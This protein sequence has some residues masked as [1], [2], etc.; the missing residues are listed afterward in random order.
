[1]NAAA[2]YHEARTPLCCALDPET[3][4]ITLRTGQEVD[5]VTLIYADPYEAGIAGGEESWQGR[6]MEMRPAAQ[7]EHC[8]LWRA[9]LR[10]PYRRLRY[11]FEVGQGGEA[12]YYYEDGLRSK[13]QLDNRVQCFTMPWM[14]PSDVIAPPDWVRQTVWYQIFPDRFCRGGSGRPGGLPW[15]DGPVTNADRFGGDLAGITAKLPYLA[16]LG[17]NG[18]YL[19]PLFASGSIHKYDTTDYA[20]VDPDFGTEADLEQLVRTAHSLGIRVMLDAVFNH[21]GPGFAPWRDVVGHGPSSPY[22]NWFFIRQWPF[23][24]G[25]T[26]DGRYF[27]FAFHGGMP[28]LNTNNPDVQEYLT[29][30]CES[31]V[32]RYD[33][34]A[35]RFDVGNEIAHSF[36]RRLRARLKARKPSL[37]LLGEIWHDAPA[38]LEG[39]E[40]DAVM[41]Y[42]LQSAIR[43]FF[44]DKAQP[45]AAFGWDVGRCMSVYAPQVNTV[46]FTLLDS[47]DTI[48]LRNRVSGEAEFWQQL[49]ALFTLPGSPCVYY[50]T[51]LMLEGGPDPD[52]RR[53]MPWARLEAEGPH[54]VLCQL[55]ALRRQEPA[56]QSSEIQ[57]L[58]GEGRLVRYRRGEP[59]PGQL[60]VCLNAGRR[61]EA[62]G[63]GGAD[64]FALA[65]DGETLAPGGI[66]IRRV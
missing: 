18:L 59:G 49:A 10:P 32:Q 3:L 57:F 39:D 29:A 2:I 38:W 51:E 24:E 9:V 19:N 47:H 25:E 61:P 4:Q 63:P 20:R 33:I 64:L 1:M 21:C 43:R 54:P 65:W 50:G 28:K 26:R 7:L 31:W 60:E 15:R 5:R 44:E 34:D 14:N 45:A 41:H 58:P 17:V 13:L 16:R 22:W 37:Y 55:I 11:C 53:C 56:F 23:Q 42:P 35:I 8:Q 52:C 62:V 27:S 36:L 12:W 30:L 40:Y 66:L 6:R 48:R 46:Q